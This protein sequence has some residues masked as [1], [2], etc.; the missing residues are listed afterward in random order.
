M[1]TT[2][3][4]TAGTTQ[5]PGPDIAALAALLLETAM[6]HD[7]F[8]KAAPEHNWWDW[9][10]PYLSARQHGSDSAQASAAADLYM[11]N[12]H[13]VAVSRG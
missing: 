11:K 7:A 8:E 5:V 9:Y 12:V 2:D 4:N 13:G 10:A 6:H 1:S 3:S